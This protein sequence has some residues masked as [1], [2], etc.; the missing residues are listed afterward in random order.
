MKIFYIIYEFTLLIRGTLA[1]I[2]CI[3]EESLVSYV[4]IPSEASNKRF[5]CCN[6]YSS[7]SLI[8]D[9]GRTF[10]IINRVIIN[11]IPLIVVYIVEEQ[12]KAL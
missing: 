10:D 7:N 2:V 12:S 3:S 1:G 8:I 5:E 4:D 11:F 9:K 6:L